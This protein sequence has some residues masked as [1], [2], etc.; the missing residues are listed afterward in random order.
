MYLR[1]YTYW[2]FKIIVSLC[3]GFRLFSLATTTGK[4]MLRR[5][6]A[7]RSRGSRF[8]C[9]CMKETDNSCVNI[10]ATSTRP[11]VYPC[12]GAI[13]K[14]IEVEETDMGK[15][16][17]VDLCDSSTMN[18]AALDNDIVGIV[19]SN[20][21]DVKC[22]N[23]RPHNANGCHGDDCHGDNNVSFSLT[24]DSCIANECVSCQCSQC[25]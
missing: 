15:R 4:P 24:I 16:L 22:N 2:A 3:N 5:S 20:E 21:L 25:M 13:D 9:T 11:H 7:R 8:D 19:D 10:I 18:V 6:V 12:S 23:G 17:V 1:F 14:Y